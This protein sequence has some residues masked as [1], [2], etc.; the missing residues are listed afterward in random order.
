MTPYDLANFRRSFVVGVSLLVIMFAVMVATDADGTTLCQK[1]ARL[2]VVAPVF[3]AVGA[4]VSR[5]Q[6]RARWEVLALE[7]IGVSPVRIAVSGA[8]AVLALGGAAALLVSL[9]FA[10]I[11]GL[12]PRAPGAVW[13]VQPDGSALSR[14]AGV[15]VTAAG[16][17]Q[18]VAAHASNGEVAYQWPV[19]ALIVW[20][21][22]ALM[23]WAVADIGWRGRVG[24]LALAVVTGIV[25]F[26]ALAAAR[27][28]AWALLT[29]PVV[30]AVQ[31][32]WWLFGT[33][34][35]ARRIKGDKPPYAYRN[36]RD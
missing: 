25:L 36:E 9:R 34:R 27:V 32:G 30:I 35:Q 4:L 26:H 6:A 16:I 5:A 17:P 18:F 28:S 22:V 31:A 29:S 8:G 24:A 1:L 23:L 7:A 15:V 19:V 12:L 21:T 13:T 2:C 3:G 10:D 20:M 14:G 11:D 33:A